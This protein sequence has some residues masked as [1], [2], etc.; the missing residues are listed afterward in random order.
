MTPEEVDTRT[1]QHFRELQLDIRE[2]RV[3]VK[4]ELQRIK[5][6]VW[7]P[8]IAAVIQIATQLLHK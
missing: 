6:L 4:A 2:L 5:L 1:Q 8:V 7:L 3:E